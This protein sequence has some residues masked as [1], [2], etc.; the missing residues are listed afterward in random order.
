MV[1]AMRIVLIG[2][3]SA[4]KSTLGRRLAEALGCPFD[5]ELGAALRAEALA[6]DPAAHAMAPQSAFDRRVIEAELRRDALAP[7]TARRVIE[8]WH[9]GNLAYAATRSPEVFAALWPCVAAALAPAAGTV[10]V[11]PLTIARAT[12]LARL[13]EPG[14]TPDALVAYFDEVGLLATT[15]ARRLGLRVLPS[16]AT[17]A[18]P[19]DA[20]VEAV[21][22]AVDRR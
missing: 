2:P 18:T 6:I 7:A 15:L 1:S 8:T 9:P 4:G 3:H 16:L 5:D 14:P 20:L 21:C 17:D 22:R 13:R 19:V 11:Q 12:A 10:L